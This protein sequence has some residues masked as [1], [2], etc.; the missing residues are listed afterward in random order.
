MYHVGI[1]EPDGALSQTVLAGLRSAGA[2]EPALTVGAHPAA[3][4]GEERTL[5]LLAVAPGAVGWAGAGAIHPRIALLCG[6]AGP[7]GRTLQAGSAVSYGTSA[8]DTLT[9]SSLEGDQI[10]VAVQRELVTVSGGSVERQELVLP[11]P[12]GCSPLPWL[13]AV[14]TLLLLG[15]EPERLME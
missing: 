3:F 9:L 8:R 13:A 2:A 7:L 15:V 4:A 14:G 12:V 11:F 5:D 1:W 10:C 6:A